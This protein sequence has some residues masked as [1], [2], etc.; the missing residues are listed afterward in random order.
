M[1]GRV[2]FLDIFRGMALAVMIVANHLDPLPGTPGWLR[3][4]GVFHGLSLVD[5]GFPFFL[6]ILGLLLP[7]SWQRRRSSSGLVRTPL[8]FLKRYGF[9]I[10]FGL[11]G[12][13]VLG[14]HPLY[15]WG[16]LSAIGLAGVVSLPFVSL[17]G[18]VRLA[19]GLLLMLGFETLRLRGFGT[20]LVHNDAGQLGGAPGSVSWAGVILVAS[21]LGDRLSAG[22]GFVRACLALGVVLSM[23]GLT[24]T[25]LV[26]VSKPVLTLSYV[27]LC[28]GLACLAALLVLLL[29]RWAGAQLGHFVI[30]GSNPSSSTC[31]LEGFPRPAGRFSD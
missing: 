30:L 28:S 15:S 3:H 8:H 14:Q 9:M 13:A 6:F 17:P 31:S 5:L 26:P 29:D 1:A 7:S 22:R 16:V 23:V 25:P 19:V 4:A 11:A 10:A 24:L 20:W 12:N 2:R 27:L 21:S 18:S